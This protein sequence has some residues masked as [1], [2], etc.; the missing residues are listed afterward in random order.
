MTPAVRGLRLHATLTHARS[1]SLD[2]HPIIGEL[3]RY[4]PRLFAASLVVA[5]GEVVA[6]LALREPALAGSALLTAGFAALAAVAGRQVDTSGERWIAP[7]LAVGVYLL[8]L[9]GAALIPGAAISSALLPILSVV[10]LL[11]GRS[12]VGILMILAVALA[13]SAAALWAGD[14]PHPFPP[15][16]EP[17]ASMFESLTLLGIALLILGALTDFATQARSSLDSLR[18]ALEAKDATFAE[19]TAIVASLGRL[20]RRDTIEATAAAIVGRVLAN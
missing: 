11:P 9:S 4:M 16:R 1:A 20:E 3:A 7:I 17:L 6:G 13:G 10:L 8:G 5:S 18:A 19:R 2:P 15:L 14:L 12:L